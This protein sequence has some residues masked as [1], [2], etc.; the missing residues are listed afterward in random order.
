MLSQTLFL[1]L[2]T[3]TE[4]VI[5]RSLMVR[6]V[7]GSISHSGPTKLFLVSFNATLLV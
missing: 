1:Q 3:W 6:R 2:L 7:D 4:V 5:G